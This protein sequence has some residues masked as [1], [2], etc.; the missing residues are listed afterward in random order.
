M[1]TLLANY[2]SQLKNVQEGKLWM[3]ENYSQKL[4]TLDVQDAFR[5]PLPE[6]H[7]PA[8][9]ISHLTVWR[10]EA[11]LKLKYGRGSLTD[12]RP[13][14]WKSNED[15]KP[16]H[17]EELKHSYD[18]SL[19]DL[20]DILETKDDTFLDDSYYDPDFKGQFSY[21][22]LIEGMLHH[23]IYHLGQL[24]IILKLLRVY[25]P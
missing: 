15:L 21:R 25:D 13:E 18:K 2:I 22:F 11:L 14:N 16:L 12:E 3:G 20:V 5:R 10:E 23:D 9:M 8:E 1:N 4:A 7:S 6:L 17:W 19:Q 24:G